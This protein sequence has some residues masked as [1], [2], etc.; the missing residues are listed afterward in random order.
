MVGG[1]C[2][3]DQRRHFVAVVQCS[4]YR[5]Q[6]CS[7]VEGCCYG[8]GEVFD[9]DVGAVE[10]DVDMKRGLETRPLS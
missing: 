10:E 4:Q 8:L 5:E 9:G 1:P 7:E 2:E 6:S 3:D